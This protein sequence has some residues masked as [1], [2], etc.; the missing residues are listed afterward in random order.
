MLLSQ[1]PSWL[2]SP[3]PWLVYPIVYT[4]LIP[5]GLSNFVVSTCT[6]LLLNLVT[7]AVDGLIRGTA[8]AS[9]PPALS[10]SGVKSSWW[11]QVLSGIAVSSSGWLVTGLGLNESEW[12]LSV[13]SVLHGGVLN[14]LDLWGGMVAGLVYAG[15]TRSHP[16]LAG[17]GDTIAAVLPSHMVSIRSVPNDDSKVKP[18]VSPNIARA[19]TVVILASLFLARVILTSAFNYRKTDKPKARKEKKSSSSTAI[20]G[21]GEKE[22][23]NEVLKSPGRGRPSGTPNKVPKV[24]TEKPR[25]YYKQAARKT[26]VAV[27]PF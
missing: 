21:D 22:V 11:A 18:T 6:P 9:L 5:T 20:L 17:L 15:L 2:V 8:I 13:P 1:P 23:K 3:T 25:V 10:A 27:G 19:I 14:T 4:L 7:A 12:R 26:G 24:S 16:D